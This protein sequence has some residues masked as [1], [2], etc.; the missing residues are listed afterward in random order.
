MTGAQLIAPVEQ[1]ARGARPYVRLHSEDHVLLRERAAGRGMAAAT[2]ASVVLR[3]HLRTLAP[4]PERELLELRRAVG[5]LGM[6]GRNL[7][8]NARVANQAGNLT[9]LTPGGSASGAESAGRFE[10]S[11]EGANAG[12]REGLGERRWRNDSL[13]Y[14]LRYPCWICRMRHIQKWLRLCGTS[15]W[16]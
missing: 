3:A 1:V 5:E 14:D 12:E 7:N 2:Y 15:Q 4:L 13:I 10:G 8:Q 9:G 16:N 6:M 11:R